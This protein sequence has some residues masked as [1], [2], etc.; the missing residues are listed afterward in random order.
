MYQ[1]EQGGHFHFY[2]PKTDAEVEFIP[3]AAGAV[4]SL[5]LHQSGFHPAKRL[6]TQK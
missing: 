1:G 3:D 4:A 2:L 5:V 6:A